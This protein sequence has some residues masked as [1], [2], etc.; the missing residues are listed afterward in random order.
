MH[1]VG[2]NTENAFEFG[3]SPLSKLGGL[4]QYRPPGIVEQDKLLKTVE[5]KSQL[6]KNIWNANPSSKIYVK[7]PKKT[8][9]K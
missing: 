6:P 9:E 8:E 5:V 7:I 1:Y 2:D 4:E 3:S